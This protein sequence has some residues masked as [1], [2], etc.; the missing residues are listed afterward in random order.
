MWFYEAGHFISKCMS[1]KCVSKP[2]IFMREGVRLR[3]ISFLDSRL[4]AENLHGRNITFH[5]EM[6]KKSSVTV[7]LIRQE[8]GKHTMEIIGDAKLENVI[9]TVD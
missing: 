1:L 2:F 4:T 7:H 3:S 9:T 8:N 5:I 6:V